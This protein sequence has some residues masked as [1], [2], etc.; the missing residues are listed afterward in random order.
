MLKKTTYQDERKTIIDVKMF[1]SDWKL[2]KLILGNLSLLFSFY[3][4]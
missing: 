2:E 4:V 3:F 1:A